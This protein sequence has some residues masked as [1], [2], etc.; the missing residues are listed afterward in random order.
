VVAGRRL[1]VLDAVVRVHTRGGPLTVRWDGDG[2]PVLMSGPAAIVF[3]GTWRVP[4]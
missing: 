4:D 2:A 3:E 1:G